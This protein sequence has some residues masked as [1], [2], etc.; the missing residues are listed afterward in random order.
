MSPGYARAFAVVI[1][2][3][4]ASHVPYELQKTLVEL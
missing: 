3:G 2:K 4:G 1:G